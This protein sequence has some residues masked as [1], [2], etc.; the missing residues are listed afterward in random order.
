MLPWASFVSAPAARAA[1]SGAD[2]AE[3]ADAPPLAVVF[4]DD[5][6]TDPNTNGQWTI[7]RHVGDPRTEAVWDSA[8][9]AW[10]LVLPTAN[11]RGVAVFANYE[12]TATTW[13]AEFRYRVGKLGGLLDGGDGFVFMFYKDKAAY[14]VPASGAQMG[15]QLYNL[16]PVAGYGLEFDNYIQG[17]DAGSSDY[18]ALIQDDVCHALTGRQDDWIGDNTWHTV[19]FNFAEGRIRISID[20]ETTLNYQLADPD[21]SFSG[22]GFG[23]GTGSAVGDYEIDNFRLWVPD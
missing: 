10:D 13:R 12:L 17:C 7:H 16:A 20:G 22:I 3:S 1:A 4:A 8:A 18:F 6:S 21:Y 19:Q 23:A 15:F 2:M 11:D 14:G 5:F 9:R